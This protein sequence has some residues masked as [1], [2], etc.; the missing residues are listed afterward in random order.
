MNRELPAFLNSAREC[1]MQMMANATYIKDHLHEVALPADM[2]PKIEA[3]CESLMAT[4]HDILHEVVEIESLS[5]ESDAAAIPSERV[6]RIMQWLFEP[7]TELHEIIESLQLAAMR[8]H[9][10][11]PASLL[12]M[13][14]AFN[15]VN[16]FNAAGEAADAL[17]K[18]NL[19]ESSQED[20][21]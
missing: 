15:V 17:T 7:I 10:H 13:E 20:M 3:A 11:G 14:S 19:P 9:R 8:D 16:A 12:L 18:A 1:A 4:K 6:Q 5:E 21:I 2:V